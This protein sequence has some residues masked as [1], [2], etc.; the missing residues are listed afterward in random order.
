M[1][2]QQQVAEQVVNLSDEGAELVGLLLNRLNPLL[3]TENGVL[4]ETVRTAD[5]SR[6]F[7]AGKA[8]SETRRNL[9]DSM[10]RLR[11]YLRGF[12]NEISGGY[13][14]SPMGNGKRFGAIQ[15]ARKSKTDPAGCRF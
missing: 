10:V 5:V 6:R 8:L 9:T 12:E 15:V 7:G 11:N 3:F 14:Y 2:V 4:S 1:T 13:A